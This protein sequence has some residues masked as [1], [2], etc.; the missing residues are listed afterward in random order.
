AFIYST[1]A[2]LI[3]SLF[4]FRN[5]GRLYGLTRFIGAFAALLQYPLMSRTPPPSRGNDKVPP[6]ISPPLALS[7]ALL[8][9]SFLLATA[10]QVTISSVL[11][12]PE[13]PLSTLP[14]LSRPF[15]HFLPIPT[16]LPFP[17]PPTP[18]YPSS[19]TPHPPPLSPHPL[20]LS[21]HPP[22]YGKEAMKGDFSSMTAGFMA[23]L[24]GAPQHPPYPL[25]HTPPSPP[26]L[27][28]SQHSS[29]PPG[30]ARRRWGGTS[31][32]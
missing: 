5:F 21:R 1:M 4:G 32:G 7:P 11:E 28:T 25:S 6:S 23:S 26:F 12:A 8:P 2:A 24:P 17:P 20:P 3:A 15:P 19:P 18:P 31:R 14:P 27:T 10:S 13:S 29:P 9:H 22:R 30:T 16:F